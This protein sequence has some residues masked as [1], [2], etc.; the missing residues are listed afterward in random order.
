MT[1]DTTTH[2]IGNNK[3]EKIGIEE[4]ITG[5]RTSSSTDRDV[6]LTLA[7]TT[8]DKPTEAVSEP[9][10]DL[11]FISLYF[12]FLYSSILPKFLILSFGLQAFF[13]FFLFVDYFFI[14]LFKD[15]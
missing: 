6:L 2:R 7:K 9:K 14:F 12:D 8:I 11:Y 13:L 10:I 5:N 4:E 3:D 1:G 15:D